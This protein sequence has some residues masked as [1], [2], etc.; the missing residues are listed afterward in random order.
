MLCP[1]QTTSAALGYLLLFIDQVGLI[2]GGPML[3]ESMYQGS[4]SSIWQ[5]PGFW[6]RQP[7]SPAAVLPLN[8]LSTGSTG[9]AAVGQAAYTSTSSRWGL[10]LLGYTWHAV[11]MLMLMHC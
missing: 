8:V 11:L 5:P 2:M 3:H 4:T 10:S 9:A 6:T 7:R 1:A